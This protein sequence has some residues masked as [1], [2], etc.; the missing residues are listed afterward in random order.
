MELFDS[1]YNWYIFSFVIF[2]VIALKFGK[3]AILSMIDEKIEKIKHDLQEAENLHTEAQEMLAQYQ[4][5]HRDALQEAEQ[6]IETAKDHADMQMKQADAD[7]KALM[8]RREAQL[9]ERIR[10]MEEN[11]K[12]E[13]RT[14]AADLSINAASEIIREK[15][16]KKTGEALIKQSTSNI[17]KLAS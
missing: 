17:T 4:R 6:I 10:N 11:A 3:D 13:I 9:D 12:D 5:K 8:K 2:M 7:L 15:M 14:Y 1:T 16:D